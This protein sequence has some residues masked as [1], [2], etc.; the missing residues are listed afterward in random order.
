MSTRSGAFLAVA[1]VL[2]T[3]VLGGC[4]DEGGGSEAEPSRSPG[5]QQ[6]AEVSLREAG[7]L[8]KVL[9]DGE[10]HT[11][12]LFE[13]DTS[14]K[15]TCDGDC[16]E[17]WPPLTTSGKPEAGDGV[18]ADLLSTSTR[19]DGKKQVVYDGHPLYYF[20]GDGKAGDTNGQDLDQF[21]AEWYVLD[22]E[23]EKVEGKGTG[24]EENESPGNGY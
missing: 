4:S 23:G 17:A 2:L 16:A 13:A 8:G 22:A 5:T 9:T 7:E 11:L 24:G 6:K 14:A 18:K 21:G 1:A 19:E 10:G 20:Q 12:Y 15:S 3:A